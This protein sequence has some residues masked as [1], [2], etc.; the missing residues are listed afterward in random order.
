MSVNV[1]PASPA[2]ASPSSV[3]GRSQEA[4]GVLCVRVKGCQPGNPENKVHSPVSSATVYLKTLR[5]E[6]RWGNHTSREYSRNFRI[7][8]TSFSPQSQNLQCDI[9]YSIFPLRISLFHLINRVRIGCSAHPYQGT[10]LLGSWRIDTHMPQ[11]PW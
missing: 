3:C 1:Q 6:S 10:A 4:E 5:A 11:R 8:K 7:I 9:V 2:S